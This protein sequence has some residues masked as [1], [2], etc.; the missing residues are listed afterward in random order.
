MSEDCPV[1]GEEYNHT[2]KNGYRNWWPG[3]GSEIRICTEFM[4]EAV[5]VHVVN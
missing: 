1:C 4:E 5:Y 3:D 2:V